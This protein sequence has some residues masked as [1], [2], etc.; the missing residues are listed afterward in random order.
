MDQNV[1]ATVPGSAIECQT[2]SGPLAQ[3][4]PRLRI[5]GT[6][7]LDEIDP[8]PRQSPGDLDKLLRA[9]RRVEIDA[10]AHTIRHR[11]DALDLD[12]IEP[13]RR[14]VPRPV[15]LRDRQALKERQTLRPRTRIHARQL[16]RRTALLRK[17]TSREHRQLLLEL[18]VAQFRPRMQIR[19]ALGAIIVAQ[20][21]Q[22]SGSRARRSHGIES[23]PRHQPVARD[24]DAH[25]MSA[26]ATNSSPNAHCK[27]PAM[28]SAR[29]S[30]PPLPRNAR[31]ITTIAKGK[32]IS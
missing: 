20:P 2:Q 6:G 32:A 4:L 7:I 25:Q 1:I 28:A 3:S 22:R 24:P 13:F 23:P 21:Q 5:V 10:D 8:L 29:L 16:D 17:L 27:A 15:A 30:S 12:G 14:I 26:P 18:H 9:Q 19:K 11:H 31:A